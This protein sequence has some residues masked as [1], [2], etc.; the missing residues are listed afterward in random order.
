MLDIRFVRENPDIVKENIR[1][2][3]QDA[4]LP[5]VDEVLEMDAQ[6]REAKV[7]GDYLRGQR[8]ALSK[9]IGGLMAK[10]EREEAERIKARGAE[11]GE[12]LAALDA[13]D[14]EYRGKKYSRYQINQQQRALERQV[15]AAK[16]V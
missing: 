1:K 9:Q 2:K 8:N 16:K 13:K 12:E 5:L 3:Y 7:R 10:G 6:Y 14:I 4:K 11:I 15:R